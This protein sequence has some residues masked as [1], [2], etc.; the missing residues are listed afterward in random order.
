MIM[1]NAE[2][3][4]RLAYSPFPLDKGKQYKKIQ[5]FIRLEKTGRHFF[6]SCN[7]L[8]HILT[9]TFLKAVNMPMAFLP[10]ISAGII[11]GSFLNIVKEAIIV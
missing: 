10:A 3:N 5:K 9:R 11:V 6:P 8:L 1:K 7:P 2:E 4:R